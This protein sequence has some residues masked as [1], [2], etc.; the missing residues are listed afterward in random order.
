MIPALVSGWKS[1]G[2]W[3][4]QPAAPAAQDV[5]KGR[6]GGKGGAFAKW[7]KEQDHRPIVGVGAGPH[8]QGHGMVMNEDGK[9]R[10]RRSIGMMRKVLGGASS[11]GGLEELGIEFRE[12]DQDERL[13]NVTLNEGLVQ[14][15]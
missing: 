14:G 2:N 11:D 4:P 8:D 13:K 5:K 3:P 6:P 1:E 7:R 15:H 9:S 12:Q 10:V